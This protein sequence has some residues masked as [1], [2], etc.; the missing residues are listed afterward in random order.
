MRPIGFSISPKMILETI[1][2][3]TGSLQISVDT[4]CED[5]FVK[6]MFCKRKAI[7]VQNS[8]R[9]STTAHEESDTFVI[10][11]SF[12]NK[13]AH[14][15]DSAKVSQICVAEI[16]ISSSALRLFSLNTNEAAHEIEVSIAKASPIR[17]QMRRHL[18]RAY[19]VR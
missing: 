18:N 17:R 19:K 2:V 3:K 14:G 5:I 9:Y 6:A 1:A 8:A 10:E 15:M 7:N 11:K 12:S 4:V 16:V 13:N